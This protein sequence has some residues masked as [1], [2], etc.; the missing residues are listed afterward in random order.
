MDDV[1]HGVMEKIHETHLS[2][3]FWCEGKRF[4]RLG[5]FQVKIVKRSPERE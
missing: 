3:H 1:C 5:P 2:S 4:K